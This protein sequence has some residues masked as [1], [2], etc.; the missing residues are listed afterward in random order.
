MNK[1]NSNILIS[2]L[3]LRDIHINDHRGN[4]QCRASNEYDE[5]SSVLQLRIR[6]KNAWIIPLLGIFIQI[7]IIFTCVMMCPNKKV[8]RHEK[9]IPPTIKMLPPSADMMV[10]VNESKKSQVSTVGS[11]IPT[12]A[13]RKALA[14][15]YSQE[16]LHKNIHLD[17][18]MASSK[19]SDPVITFKF[20]KSRQNRATESFES[21]NELLGHL[22]TIGSDDSGVDWVETKLNNPTVHKT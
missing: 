17:K 18:T 13:Q 16:S 14:R 1:D 20:G 15:C 10:I 12:A 2:K 5:T 4:F 8:R 6:D 3:N 22:G 19:H 7:F 21:A 9:A 11:N